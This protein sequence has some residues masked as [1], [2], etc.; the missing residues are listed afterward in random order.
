MS[1]CDEGYAG[2][3]EVRHE[4]LSFGTVRIQSDVHRVAVVEAQ[5][6]VHSRLSISAYGH[7]MSEFL[8]EESANHS[9]VSQTPLGCAVEA[10]ISGSLNHLT[11]SYR[12]LIIG[13]GG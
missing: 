3:T 8:L 4:G 9:T 11:I 5:S 13:D 1:E 12:R 10:Y 2:L 6:I 7:R